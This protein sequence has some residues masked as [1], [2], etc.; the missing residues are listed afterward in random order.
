MT[1]LI[2]LASESAIYQSSDYR[3][4]WQGKPIETANGAKQLSVRARN[5]TAIIAFTGIAAD[6]QG[7]I[8]RDWLCEEGV[9]LDPMSVPATFV[10]NVARRGSEKLK[11][12]TNFSRQ[13]TVVV[14]I[15]SLGRCRLFVVS[16][17]EEHGKNP[18]RVPL[19]TLR[20]FEVDLS[21]PTLM[22]NGAQGSLPRWEKKSLERMF[23][24][25]PDPKVMR[26]R[27]AT[28]NQLA[29]SRRG[30]VE[31][32]SQGC[33]V[34]SVFADGRSAGLNYGQVPGIPL[35]VAT[36]IEFSGM[37][38]NLLRPAPGKQVAIVQSISVIGSSSPLPAEIGEPREI[39]ISTPTTSMKGIGQA[40]GS[41]FPQ[42]E[43][44]GLSCTVEV[45][46]N[47][48]VKALLN[49]VTFEIDPKREDSGVPLAFERLQLPNVP[50]VD[51]AQPRTWDYVFDLHL[52]GGTAVL[53]ISQNS[54][55]LRATNC[56]TGL[57]ALGP[58]EELVMAAPSGGMIL[59]ATPDEPRVFGQ[60]EA[61]FLLRDFPEETQA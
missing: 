44:G 7:Y 48:W 28:A 35:E 6:G 37:L 58:T 61:T 51:G 32:I 8:T 21:S 57:D 26:D 33:W 29:A 15:A 25:N 3:L 27:I 30:F 56:G 12:V 4:S 9:S 16:N 52:G 5:W 41:E 53:T 10:E 24:N 54:V 47:V 45:R 50:T 34:T 18:L 60:I 2:T 19:D 39:R 17:F 22:V 13:L 36:G 46:K 42:L 23:R 1:L 40:A 43:I 38:R 55:A 31:T 59:Y 20:T 14:A 11:L 49:T